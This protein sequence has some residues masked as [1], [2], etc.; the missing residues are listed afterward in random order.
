MPQHPVELILTKQLASYLA[1][2]IF[3]VNPEG[4]LLFYNEPAET[5]LGCRYDETGEMDLA[6][7]SSAFTPT[8]D[9]GAPLPPERL[10]L[11]IALTERKPAH[12]TFRIVG[13]DGVSRRIAVTAFPVLAQGDRD[14]GAVAMF[15]EERA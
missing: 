12:D 14:L 7:W 15:W 3:L 10:P 6:T 13:L 1:I 9:D 8:D 5:I 11:V 4:S 2:P